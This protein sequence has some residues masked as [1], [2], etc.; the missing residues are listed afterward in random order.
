VITKLLN[1]D[2]GRVRALYGEW[3]SRL[4]TVAVLEGRCPGHVYV[5]DVQNPRSALLWDHDEGELYLAGAADQTAFNRAVNGLIRNQIRSEAQAD[6]PNLSEYTL[7]GQGAWQEQ[8]EVLL[9]ETYPMRHERLYF[10]LQRPRVEWRALLPKGFVIAPLDAA[11]CGREDLEGVETLRDW[12]LGDCRTAAEFERAERG[13]CL[14]HPAA[15]ALVGWCASEYTCRPVPGGPRACEVGIYTCEPYRRQGF[16]TLVATATVEHC[17][18]AGI[19]Q[20]GWHCWGENVGSAATARKVGFE[21]ADVQPVWNA[22][23]NLFDNW[24]LQAHYHNVAGRPEEAL[25]CWERGFEMWEGKHPDAVGSPHVREHPDTV[26]WC[27][28]GAGRVCA[29]L[30]DLDAA[31]H[32]LDQALDEG[33][34]DAACLLQDEALD[35]LRGL[36]R[37]GALMA[38]CL[39]NVGKRV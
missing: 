30:G 12:V 6:L 18:E 34:Q 5:D 20:I 32:H 14:I 7:Y 24:L 1:Q 22:C 31:F 25:A 2:Y 8:I 36:P 35:V 37:W 15:S 26:G 39:Q 9:Q 28:F 16:A 23:F 19:E 13:C 33:W 17:L 3:H 29:Q 4:V 11:L 27:Y 38:C 10:V 21:L